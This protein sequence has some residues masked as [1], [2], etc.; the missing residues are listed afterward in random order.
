[1]AS[2]DGLVLVYGATGQQGGPVARRLLAAGRRTRVLTRDPDRAESLREAGAEIAVGDLGNPASLEAASEG[3][4]RIFFHVPTVY[5]IDVGT[6]YGRNAIDAAVSAGIGLFVFDT[7]FPVASEPTDVAANEIRRELQAYLQRSGIPH[8]VIRPT[9]YIE[10]YYLPVTAPEDI[11]RQGILRY[12]PLPRDMRVSW[13]SLE[14][15]GALAVEAL[16]RPELAGSVFDVGGPEALTGDEVAERFAAILDRPVTY[17]P[18][19][20]DEYEQMLSTFLGKALGKG[21]TSQVRYYA[22]HPHLLAVSDMQTVLREL[23]VRLTTFERC[24]GR[25]PLFTP[26]QAGT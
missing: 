3:V 25:M 16:S 17:D 6:A 9:F 4:G 1:M 23:P 8:I 19:S 26:R 5:D 24:I 18:F 11:V 2:Q 21:V 15:V 12:P 7:S 14:D 10:N 20:F 13:I 22:K